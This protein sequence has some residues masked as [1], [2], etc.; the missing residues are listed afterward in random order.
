[1]VTTGTEAV[2]QRYAEVQAALL[3]AVAGE[4]ARA[5]AGPDPHAVDLLGDPQAAY[6]VIHLTGTNGK[7]SPP[8]A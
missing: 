8:R 7:G 5:V 6:P 4:Q 2:E 1:M 3:L